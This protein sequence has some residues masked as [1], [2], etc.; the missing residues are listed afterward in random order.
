MCGI[1]FESGSDLNDEL[2]S[3]NLDLISH[4]GPDHK[5]FVKIKNK[6]FGHVRLSI[7][8]LSSDGNQPMFSSCGN[9]L[10]IFNGEIYNFIKIK[11][12]LLDL[13]YKFKTKTDTEVILN[14]FIHYKEEITSM[15]SGMFSFCIYD[16]N[17]D[18]VF[19]ARD[20][21]G[22]KPLYYYHQN[23]KMIIS[24]EA[25]VFK[26][27]KFSINHESKILFMLLGSIPGPATI[28]KIHSFPSKSCF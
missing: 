13:G 21:S 25:R 3:K 22:I 7:I 18:S 4:R 19:I 24:S 5:S 14:G 6:L 1:L 17:D 2:F 12:K 16:L 15:L 20:R 8:D 27:R 10:I 28:Y 11:N 23:D 26:T 9:Y